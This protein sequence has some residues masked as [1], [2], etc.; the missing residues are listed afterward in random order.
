M[1]SPHSSQSSNN[2]SSQNNSNPHVIQC[3]IVVNMQNTQG[4]IETATKEHM[5]FLAS[6]L[7]SYESLVAGRIGNS[8][9][10]KEDFD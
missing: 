6:T 9:M 5:T 8:Y 3:N 2:C 1:Q 10:T 4:L 7:E